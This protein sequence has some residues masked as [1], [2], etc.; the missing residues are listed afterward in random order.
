[1]TPRIC[2][3][4]WATEEEVLTLSDF[5]VWNGNT[6]TTGCTYSG[7]YREVSRIASHVLRTA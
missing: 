3:H 4:P 7:W 2:R 1:M 6:D 5:Q